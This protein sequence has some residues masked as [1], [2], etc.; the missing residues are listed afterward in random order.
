MKLAAFQH[1]LWTLIP[2]QQHKVCIKGASQTAIYAG[3][4]LE[5][6]NNV[7]AW[8]QSIL[9]LPHP[10][11]D[12]HTKLYLNTRSEYRAEGWRGWHFFGAMGSWQLAPNLLCAWSWLRHC[13]LD[14]AGCHRTLTELC[15]SPLPTRCSTPEKGWATGCSGEQNVVGPLKEWILPNWETVTAQ[16]QTHSKVQWNVIRHTAACGSNQRSFLSSGS[17]DTFDAT[18]QDLKGW[19]SCI[20]RAK[21]L[22]FLSVS[23]LSL[24]H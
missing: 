18:N 12:C 10:F 21:G 5:G 8:L 13:R 16:L 6:P 23:L 1:A 19:S 7:L 22:W 4:G 2:P 17:S 14:R 9:H 3:E 15:S 11:E 20:Q 24:R